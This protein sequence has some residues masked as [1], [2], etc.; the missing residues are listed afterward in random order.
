MMESQAAVGDHG[1]DEENKRQLHF[2]GLRSQTQVSGCLLH[3]VLHGCLDFGAHNG[4]IQAGAPDRLGAGG[5]L[6]EECRGSGGSGPGLAG[7]PVEAANVLEQRF[8]QFE[9]GHGFIG[10]LGTVM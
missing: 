10:E 6:G 7:D 4:V 8:G 2:L 3:K 1:I 5:G 9:Q